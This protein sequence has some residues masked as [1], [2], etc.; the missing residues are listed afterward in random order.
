MPAINIPDT[1]I[2]TNANIF[3]TMK[4]ECL[5]QN[6]KQYNRW[7]EILKNQPESEKRPLRLGLKYCTAELKRRNLLL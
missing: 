4:D 5:L 2:T 3:Q 7:L 1:A 6:Y